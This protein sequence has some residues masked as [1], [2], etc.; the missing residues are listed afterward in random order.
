MGGFWSKANHSCLCR[1]FKWTSTRDR[2]YQQPGSRCGNPLHQM[3]AFAKACPLRPGLIPS[4]LQ[5]L[6]YWK[7]RWH[8]LAQRHFQTINNDNDRNTASQPPFSSS[9]NYSN[10]KTAPGFPCKFSVTYCKYQTTH[11]ELLTTTAG[12]SPEQNRFTQAIVNQVR[13]YQYWLQQQQANNKRRSNK[14]DH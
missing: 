2:S 4:P 13:D 6:G 10:F 8:R 9:A 11:W 7:A 12:P 3:G 5:T 1:P 14:A